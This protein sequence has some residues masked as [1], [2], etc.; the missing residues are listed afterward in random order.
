MSIKRLK[1]VLALGLVVG[2]ALLINH[3]GPLTVIRDLQGRSAAPDFVLTDVDG[4]QMRLSDY[5]GKVVLLNFWATW[6]GPCEYEIPWF[7]EFEN[8]YKD[9]GFAVLGVSLDEDGWKSVRPY[10]EQKKMNYRVALGDDTTTHRYGGIEALPESLLIDRDGRIA[11]KQIGLASKR[12]Y[13][14]GIRQLL[15]Q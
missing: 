2:L 15:R 12:S 6:C 11:A 5:K 3:V 10:M 13:E 7:V 9:S 4:R 1:F 14:E 8:K